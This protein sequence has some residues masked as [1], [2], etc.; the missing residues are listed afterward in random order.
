MIERS[1]PLLAIC[2]AV[3]LSAD[4]TAETTAIVGARVHTM[5]GE[6]PIDDAVVVIRDGRI[7]EVGPGLEPPRDARLIDAEGWIVTPAFMNSATQLGLT[8]IASVAATNDHALT[9]GPLGAAFDV[10]YA[11]DPNSALIRQARADGVSRAMTLPT[12]SPTAPLA[13]LGA[14]LH[15]TPGSDVLERPR[16]AMLARIG[17]DSAHRAGGSRSAEW[18]LLRNAL[19]EAKAYRPSARPGA[20]RDSFLS[21]IDLLALKE[22]AEARIPLI[23]ETDRE[24][25]IRQAL[26]LAADY[27]L[28]LILQGGIEAWRV[29]APLAAA[30]IPVILDSSVNLPLRFDELGVRADNAALLQRAGVTIAFTVSGVHTSYNAG[31]ALREV[32]GLAVA[33]GLSRHAA[34]RALT[35]N[36]A[37]IWGIA[38]RYGTIA[39]GMEADLVLWDGD[40]LEPLSAPA[41]VLIGG[42]EVS[43]V[44]RQTELRDRYA[45]RAGGGDGLPPAYR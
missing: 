33:N 5:L 36:P 42:E 1:A 37:G 39:P 20:R 15:L 9:G 21:R 23:V 35:V 3:L 10:Q 18:L 41:A 28:R 17:G 44:T 43:L 40:P 8:E 29:A 11:I 13:G 12:G 34:L 25:D 45:P 30:G 19:D 6:S 4:A 24:S 14:L 22:V 26:A 16:A 31:F 32:A 2:G 7:A 38:E 27:R